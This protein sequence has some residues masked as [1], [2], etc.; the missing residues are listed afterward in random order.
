MTAWQ[1][2]DHP[3]SLDRPAWPELPEPGDLAEPAAPEP[4]A[5]PAQPVVAVFDFDGTLT[6]RHTMWR[7][8][9]FVVTPRVFWPALA[10]LGPV[11]ARRSDH[12]H[13]GSAAM[14]AR[15]SL[16]ARFLTGM[17]SDVAAHHARRFVA[18][19]LRGWIRPAALARLRWHQARGHRT[20]LVSNSFETYLVPWGQSVGFDDVLG[21]QL[22]VVDGRLTGQ[23][24]SA[25]C[26]GPEKVRRLTER[27][28]ELDRFR[29]YAYG[30]STGDRELLDSA[31]QPF[32]RNW[33]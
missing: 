30:D 11:L 29:I 32:Y 10:S 6:D 26:V 12:L 20:V 16:V 18:G 15:R 13:G 3:A 23:I 14:A 25:D 19:P 27:I 28:G 33:Y 2:L 31:T 22:E 8:L 5:A 17:S 9:R 24:A 4:A 21:T 1:Q 7:F